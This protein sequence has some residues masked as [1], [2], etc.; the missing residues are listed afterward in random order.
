MTTT[1]E[2]QTTQQLATWYYLPQY[3][4]NAVRKMVVTSEPNNRLLSE[5]NVATIATCRF[6]GRS[7]PSTETSVA[8]ES[9]ENAHDH[10]QHVILSG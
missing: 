2:K 1:A 3:L 6:V 5:L 9:W 7:W 8:E 10:L 4:T